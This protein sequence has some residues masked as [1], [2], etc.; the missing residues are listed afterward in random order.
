MPCGLSKPGQLAE[1]VRSSIVALGY[2]PEQ[3]KVRMFDARRES[4][5]RT[6]G[7]DRDFTSSVQHVDGFEPMLMRIFGISS[8]QQ[9]TY[10]SD[11]LRWS[12]TT[13][14]TQGWHDAVVVYDATQ[15]FKIGDE[16][17]GFHAFLTSARS[18]I[19][20]IFRPNGAQ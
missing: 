1:H 2:A 13:H 19:I 11:L 6:T 12:R 20:A 14:L 5:V 17:S 18:A 7:T 4:W 3:I 8:P 10:V 15:L 9:A 16:S